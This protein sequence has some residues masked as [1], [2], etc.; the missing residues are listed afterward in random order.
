MKYANG[1]FYVGG[2][3]GVNRQGQG[4]LIKADGTVQEGIW[5]KDNLKKN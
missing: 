4:K 3:D 5:E 1:D 2:F